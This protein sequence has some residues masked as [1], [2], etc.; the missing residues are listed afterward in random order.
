MLLADVSSAA[1]VWNVTGASP[2]DWNVAANWTAG[3]PVAVA[4]S[5][6]KAVF[7]L[8]NRAECEVTAAQSFGQLVQ[9][10]NG[11]GGV[12]RIRDGGSLSSGNNWTAI[13]YNRQAHM[14]VETGGVLN[15]ASHLWIGHLS[16]GT[17]TLDIDGG[18]FNV[19]GQLGLGWDGGPG[20]VNFTNDG[21]L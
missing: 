15:C 14:L 11:P 21:V 20:E 17:G 16:P 8:S 19:A 1:T 7:S 3:V 9:G 12:I 5:E 4:P 6:T 2:A 10:D 18:T 13:G